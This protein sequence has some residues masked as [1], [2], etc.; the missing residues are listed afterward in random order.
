MKICL[1]KTS[2]LGDILHTF[3]VLAYLRKRYPEA[4][5]DWMVERPF[6]D[7]LRAHPEVDGVL[8]VDTKEWRRHVFARKTWGAFLEARKRMRQTDYDLLFDLQ[9]NLKSGI[10]TAQVKADQK[11]GPN[12]SSAAEVL[13]PFFTH[14]HI[15]LQKN[16]NV[17]AALLKLVQDYFNDQEPFKE[18]S[19]NL[20]LSS[21][22]QREV[23]QLFQQLNRGGPSA[24]RILVAPGSMWKNKQ[25]T[26]LQLLAF[27]QRVQAV[28][29]AHYLFSWGSQEELAQASLISS[30]LPG[31]QVL[32]KRYSLPQ[33]SAIIQQV[34]LLIGMDSLPL[35]LA[36]AT[37]QTAT[38][39][40]F[41]PS[42]AKVYNPAGARHGV[43]QGQC[44]YG[45][46]MVTR[47]PKLRRCPTGACLRDVDGDALF[48]AFLKNS[49]DIRL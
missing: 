16:I 47:C 28:T 2:S 7:L 48:E 24:Y 41:G 22:E 42:S 13:N 30:A 31:S 15:S 36:A 34:N 37:S 35:H 21:A 17:R 44:P 6:A 3:P 9:G 18:P 1:V 8:E 32:A 33:L 38:F 39:A 29:N 40:F 43:F 5:I 45:M 19:V 12:W 20:K 26:H 27:L 4:Q 25:L 11:V 10:L 14:H 23:E 46:Q 49:P